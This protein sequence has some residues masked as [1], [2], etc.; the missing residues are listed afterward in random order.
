MDRAL[1]GPR[2]KPD[3][4]GFLN[5][6][7]ESRIVSDFRF[8]KDELFRLF[9]VLRIPRKVRTPSGCVYNGL[10]AMLVM[11]RRLGTAG[12]VN[13]FMHTFGIGEARVSELFNHMIKQTIRRWGHLLTDCRPFRPHFK[14]Y[15]R[16]IRRSGATVKRCVGFVDGNDLP[17]AKPSKFERYTFSGK[18]RMHLL[19]HQ[20]F[21]SPNGMIMH[22]FGPCA[23]SITDSTMLGKSRLQRQMRSVCGAP[24]ER[25]HYFIYG[26]PAYAMTDYIMTPCGHGDISRR[27]NRFNINMARKRIAVEWAFGKMQEE[28]PFFCVKKEQKIFSA[29]VSNRYKVA[30]LLTNFRTCLYGSNAS[31]YFGVPT[32]SLESYVR[33]N[34]DA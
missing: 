10:Y 19:K 33:G 16:A 30:A 15:A 21:V 34:P 1:D 32:P 31:R 23:G 24:G 6:Q 11:L 25:H 7:H 29:P 22:F 17:I 3:P 8:R 18:S 26:D 13:D 20:G 27:Q 14:K 4:V 2:L 12:T 9:R 28:W 5:Y